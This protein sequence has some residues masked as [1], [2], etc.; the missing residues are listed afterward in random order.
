VELRA[1]G[2]KEEA[3]VRKD[4]DED[5]DGQIAFVNKETCTATKD[6]TDFRVPQSRRIQPNAPILLINA[7]VDNIVNSSVNVNNINVNTYNEQLFDL[8]IE[9]QE[10]ITLKK[11]EKLVEEM[12]IKL[13][14]DVNRTIKGL[15]ESVNKTVEEKVKLAM[16]KLKPTERFSFPLPDK[17]DAKLLDDMRLTQRQLEVEVNSVKSLNFK[18]QDKKLRVVKVFEEAILLRDQFRNEFKQAKQH[19][20]DLN[21]FKSSFPLV[22]QVNS[23]IT[24]KSLQG[25]QIQREI[26]CVMTGEMIPEIYH[27]YLDQSQDLKTLKGIYTSIRDRHLWKVKGYVPKPIAV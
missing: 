13:E 12:K 20:Q 22:P 9:K 25:D 19:L 5:K 3:P 26:R 24:Q 8:K 17:V 2:E 1:S 4:D 15:E 10:T 16:E 21:T 23:T 18:A 27:K 11:A 7:P 6:H 14:A